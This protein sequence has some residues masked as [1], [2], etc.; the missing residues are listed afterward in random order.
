MNE[1]LSIRAFA[2]GLIYGRLNVVLES[3][4]GNRSSSIEFISVQVIFSFSINYEWD[5]VLTFIILSFWEFWIEGAL[6]TPQADSITDS[7]DS[8]ETETF[9]LLFNEIISDRC[10]NKKSSSLLNWS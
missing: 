9:Y 2:E 8:I 6:L 10:V 4:L 3:S 5:Y 1:L 7:C